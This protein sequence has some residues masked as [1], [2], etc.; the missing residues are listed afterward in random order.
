MLYGGM[1][2]NDWYAMGRV[3]VGSYREDMR[4]ALLLGGD[5]SGVSSDSLG[6]YE[7][8]YGE[9][10]YR[11]HLGNALITP[12]M[13]LQYAQIERGA[14]N[15][16]G[17][18]GFGLKSGDQNIERWQAGLGVRSTQQ[19]SLGSAGNLG[20]QF[21]FLWQQAFAMHGEVFDASFDAL[22]QWAP[23]GGIGVSRYGGVAG[24]TLNWDFNRRSSLV[25]GYDQHFDQHQLGKTATLT[26]RWQ[27]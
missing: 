12:Y 6:R 5:S 9:S 13:N 4:R 26:Y 16:L 19:W 20:L 11:F 14:I 1:I 22:N 24:A 25:A 8:A 15:E 23:V 10:G 7:V 2:K 27:F 3:G 18:D 21:R 17:G